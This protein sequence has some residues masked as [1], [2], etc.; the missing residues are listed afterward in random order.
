VSAL[1]VTYGLSPLG[2]EGS[3][4][5]TAAADLSAFRDCQEFTKY[6]RA[7]TAKEVG[8]YGYGPGP[9]LY[10]GAQP[11]TDARGGAPAP[12]AAAP[13]E[14]V[15]NNAT[16]TN[17]QE[18]GVDE[19]DVAKVDGSRLLTL[20]EGKLT[21]VQTAGTKPKLL[22]TLAFAEGEYPTE[23]FVLP[24]NRAL[25]IGSAWEPGPEARPTASKRAPGFAPDRY[26][27]GTSQVALTLVDTSGTTM[28][29]LRSA[30]VTGN[31]VSARLSDGVVRIVFGSQPRIYFQP[32][33]EAEPDAVAEARNR[34][35][36]RNAKTEAFL[37]ERT[38][39]SKDGKVLSRAPLVGCTD[40]RRPVRPSGTGM[41]SVLNLDTDKGVNLFDAKG[42]GI[43]ANGD[44]VY[45]STKRLY[46]ATTEGGWG[47]NRPWMG[48]TRKQASDQRVTA[49]HAFDATGRGI[50]RYIGSGAV[51]GYALGRW[52]FSEHKGYLRVATTTGEPWAPPEQGQVSESRVTV[53]DETRD[54]LRKVGD[55]S[56]LG[57]TERIRGIRWFGD[58]AAIVTFRQTDPLYMVDLSKPARP[59]VRGELKIPGYSA[60]L[61]P[62]GA[63]Q[64]L[65]IGQDADA[66]GRVTGLLTQ[67]FDVSDVTK[68]TRTDKLGLG[69]GYTEVEHDSRAFTYLTGR[70]LAVIPAWVNQKV[71]CPPDAQCAAGGPGRPG[72]AGEISVPAAIGV[73]IDKSGNL[74]RAGKFIGDTQILR[75][76]PIGDRL[77]AVT[78][79]SVYLLDPDGMK[80]ISSVRISSQ[81][82][83]R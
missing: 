43:V 61:H 36:V 26:P 54:G 79:T 39:R 31:Y 68:P 4:A 8:P 75:V 17:V 42:T 58:L 83:G 48:T 66:E 19:P 23:L 5:A 51:P 38:I 9:V 57:K 76:I 10:K 41:L 37:P 64:L 22:D 50:S 81:P 6:M 32:R 69:K 44:V 7:E 25:V 46:V 53:L 47:W 24:R 71:T 78:A 1:A 34:Q 40:V 62:T 28:E 35:T 60:Y 52:A 15:G 16:G 80:Q 49:I 73:V 13:Q 14:A 11:M 67:A 63:G 65:G 2:V 82:Q 3:A 29:V 56:G 77:A 18:R 59:R 72:F 45:A 20:T 30:R 33:A 12:E 74:T 70:R 21:M 27:S 55:V